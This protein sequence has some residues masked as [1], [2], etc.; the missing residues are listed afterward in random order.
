MVFNPRFTSKDTE[1]DAHAIVEAKLQLVTKQMETELLVAD[2]S[3]VANPSPIFQS[4]PHIVVMEN[5]IVGLDQRT[6]LAISANGKVDANGL[7]KEVVVSLA[8]VGDKKIQAADVEL[9]WVFRPTER[10]GLVEAGIVLGAAVN[11][12]GIQ[13]VKLLPRHDC[14]SEITKA[15]FVH[16]VGIPEGHGA[17]V[18]RPPKNRP[19]VFAHQDDTGVVTQRTVGVGLSSE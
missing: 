3:G 8:E 17:V 2:E 16:R 6:I 12:V 11:V 14:G 10:E 5:L 18:K 1:V 7:V 19:V 4:I 15:I 9:D 13:A